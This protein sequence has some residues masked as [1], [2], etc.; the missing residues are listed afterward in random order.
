MG[1]SVRTCA[2][3]SVCVCVYVSSC[4]REWAS[5]CVY[6][7]A[8]AC[9][10]WCVHILRQHLPTD[11]LR[12]EELI[13]SGVDDDDVMGLVP[14]AVACVGFRSDDITPISGSLGRPP[15]TI[16]LSILFTEHQH[17]LLQRI[18]NGAITAG[19]YYSDRLLAN[20]C[21][22]HSCLAILEILRHSNCSD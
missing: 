13:A 3:V 18:E 8:C 20:R 14:V 6:A 11:G 2:C 7:C 21:L 16:A 12:V 15:E 19:V 9:A 17:D 5:A 22:V 1:A 4:V 10:C